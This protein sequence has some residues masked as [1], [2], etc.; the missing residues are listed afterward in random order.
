MTEEHRALTELLK[1]VDDSE[2]ALR[3]LRRVTRG[4]ILAGFIFEFVAGFTLTISPL[5]HPFLVHFCGVFGGVALGAAACLRQ[6]AKQWP[7]L[8]PHINRKSVKLRLKELGN[9]VSGLP[10]E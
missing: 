1:Q 9:A 5:S 7:F 8:R 2:G 6:M 3:S 4:L 10:G